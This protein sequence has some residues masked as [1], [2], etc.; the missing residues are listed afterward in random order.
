MKVRF[1]VSIAGANWSARP[2]QVLDVPALEAA[3][4][5]AAG[6]AEA[7]EPV[8]LYLTID[9][10]NHTGDPAESFLAAEVVDPAAESTGRCACNRYTLAN[11]ARK[12]HVCGAE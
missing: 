2:K 1:L 5:I 3:R 11:A 4:Y 7:I 9:A 10:T 12:Q 8:G 6:I